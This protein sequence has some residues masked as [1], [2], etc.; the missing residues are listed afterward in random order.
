MSTLPC[1]TSGAVCAANPTQPP[2]V[3]LLHK[4]LE[5]SPSSNGSEVQP[6]LSSPHKAEYEES[7]AEVDRL[8]TEIEKMKK[9]M[10]YAPATNCHSIV[11]E[12]ASD[13]HLFRHTP[14]WS[15]NQEHSPYS[16][17]PREL[18]WRAPT[19]PPLRGP[20]VPMWH[21]PR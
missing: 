10:N 15:S 13:L 20:R 7:L 5:L 11:A 4:S 19:H 12:H 8:N 2:A 1:V 3:P 9:K 6:D 17:Q 14:G 16:M 18:N 21:R